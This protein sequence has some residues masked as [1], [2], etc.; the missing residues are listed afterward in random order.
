MTGST[1]TGGQRRTPRTAISSVIPQERRSESS[2]ARV[3]FDKSLA[4]TSEAAPGSGQWNAASQ[5]GGCRGVMMSSYRQLVNY[6]AGRDPGTGGVLTYF[7]GQAGSPGYAVTPQTFDQIFASAEAQP[8]GARNLAGVL[9]IAEDE[10]RGRGGQ[11][12]LLVDVLLTTGEPQDA[13]RTLAWFRSAGRDHIIVVGLYGTSEQVQPAQEWYDKIA[14]E[15]RE[16]NDGQRYMHVYNFEQ[17]TD[18]DEIGA[19]LTKALS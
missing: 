15:V 17:V 18:A 16:H 2:E 14:D 19:D 10:L 8:N 6:L 12:G 1:Q 5:S 3:F 9:R 7:Y 4:T 11:R 13:E